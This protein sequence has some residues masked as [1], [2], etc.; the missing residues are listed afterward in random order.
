MIYV[1]VKFKTIN[2]AI[3]CI[4]KP[5][6]LGTFDTTYNANDVYLGYSFSQKLIYMKKLALQ[7][8]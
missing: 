3:L 7:Q 8:L 1:L 6:C 5:Q 4:I 2:I